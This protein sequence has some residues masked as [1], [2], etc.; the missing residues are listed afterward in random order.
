MCYS[1]GALQAFLDG[2]M[3]ESERRQVEE[4]LRSCEACRQLLARL[5]KGQDLVDR[6]V[7]TYLANQHLTAA[8]VEMG[9]NRLQDKLRPAKR[10]SWYV[11]ARKHRLAL[12]GIAAVL[13]LAIG[14]SFGSVRAAAGRFLSVF[15]VNRFQAITVTPQDLARVESMVRDGIG[16][17][18]IG[19]MG[20]VE[21]KPRGPEG[22]VSLDQAKDAVDFQLRFPSRLPEGLQL[23]GL[24]ATPALEFGLTLGVEKVNQLLK[25]LGGEKMLPEELD[26]ETITL[27]IPASI[28]AQYGGK[29]ALHVIQ[30]RSPEL[31]M[32]GDAGAE[33]VREA[34]LAM[35]FLPESVKRQ[36]A[37]VDDWQHTFLV[38]NIQGSTQEVTVDGVSGLYIATPPQYVDEASGMADA[39]VWE[40][41]DVVYAVVGEFSLEQGLAIGNS[42]K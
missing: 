31:D 24:T 6:T 28:A 36:I 33:A 4:H 39:L 17:V 2:E 10:E 7:G 3:E 32:P 18:T 42:M 14:L 34:V 40:K 12:A 27:R 25:S 26:G 8:Q 15:R 1:E 9:W 5:S 16:S 11:M 38:P 37:A 41:D 35:P 13:T 30:A 23:Q 22:L 20:E 29:G 21:M 19:V